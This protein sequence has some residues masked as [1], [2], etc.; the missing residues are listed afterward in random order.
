MKTKFCLLLIQLFVIVPMIQAQSSDL[1]IQFAQELKEKCR[2]VNSIEC[3]FIQTRSASVL[4]HDATKHGRY[5]FL[6]PYNVLLAFDDGDYIKITAT[7]FE[8]KQ[9]GHISSTKVSSN[10]ML[11]SLNRM[12]SACI[13]GDASQITSGFNTEITADDD[14]FILKLLPLR[15]RT[16]GKASETILVF[17]RKDMSLKLMKMTE[18]SGDFL[19]YQFFDVKY[20]TDFSP[21]IF[22]IK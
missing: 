9:N 10:P 8:I 22:D 4:A 7:M 5:F 15:G 11:K 19:Q 12:L 6:M 1:N 20:N 16:G 13:S 17:N 21:S 3:G 2:D 14:E 18:A